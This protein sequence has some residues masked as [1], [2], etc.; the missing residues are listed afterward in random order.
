MILKSFF[1]MPQGS[2]SYFKECSKTFKKFL[3]QN[4]FIL[5]NLTITELF[6][7]FKAFSLKLSDLILAAIL[8]GRDDWDDPSLTD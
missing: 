6:R 7:L 4:H 1:V 8:E 3:K 5:L 2:S